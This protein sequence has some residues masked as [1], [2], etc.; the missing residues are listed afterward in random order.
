MRRLFVVACEIG[1]V[2]V[3]MVFR[4]FDR[5]ANDPLGWSTY[6]VGVLV[7]NVFG[8]LPALGAGH[9]FGRLIDKQIARRRGREATRAQKGT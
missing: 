5:E 1:I 4:T 3:L 6:L 9:L 2:Y 8:L 7:L